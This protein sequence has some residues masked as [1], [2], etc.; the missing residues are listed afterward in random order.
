M[1][2][3]RIL[4]ISPIPTHPV[5]AGNRARVL[6]LAS[7]IR[8][9]GYDL[10]FLHVELDAGDTKAMREYWGECYIRCKYIK[11]RNSCNNILRRIYKKLGIH[12]AY[13]YSLDEWY[14][15]S[16]D[17]FISEL[18][19]KYRFNAVISEYV[20]M[21]RSLNNFGPEVT[22]IVDTHDVFTD[23]HKHYLRE[24]QQPTWYSISAQDEAKGLNRAD[25]AIAIQKN[26][27]DYFRT[28]CS[29]RVVVIGHNVDLHS[30]DESTI[31]SNRILLV[32]SGNFINHQ[33]VSYLVKEILPIII[34]SIPNALLAIAGSI[35]KDLEDNDNI[36]KLGMVDDLLSIYKTAAVV[37]NPVRIGTG[38]KIK[39]IEAL[40]NGRP[41][42][43]T[44]VGAEGLEQ[45]SGKAFL[46]GDTSE[47]FAE[48]IIKLLTD[49]ALAKSLSAKGHDVINSCN[50]SNLE[51]IKSILG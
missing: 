29:K 46:V 51:T 48:S 4:V 28:I 44:S 25:Y 30:S 38:L 7:N 37:V 5:I 3:K 45:F 49:N 40:A 36:Q 43:T 9:L 47:L 34:K 27:A 26:E 21:S 35:C 10:I 33:A 2:K 16:T 41:L 8:K 20:Y 15:N 50:K 1:N 14:D 23:R 31:I 39:T 17:S 32:A 11:P 42:V 22:K 18:H 13:K 6:E 19:N 12:A 24:G